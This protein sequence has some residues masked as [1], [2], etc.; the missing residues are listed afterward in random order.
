MCT[1][2][3]LGSDV[4]LPTS[5]WSL[6]DPRFHVE[7]IDAEM[8]VMTRHFFKPNVYYLASHE[9]CGCGFEWDS[10]E[11]L[12]DVQEWETEWDTLSEELR[13]EIDWSRS[14]ER[15]EYENR[16]NV[17]E[18]LASLLKSVLE[19]TNDLELRVFMRG[20]WDKIPT[21]VR[22]VTPDELAQGRPDV[23]PVEGVLYRVTKEKA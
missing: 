13:N 9:G 11:Q 10:R 20:E 5:K 16:K 3:L 18:D 15:R 1:H 14:D 23:F 6:E 21:S 7:N 19:R 8:R 2:V 17:A 22:S 4:E 12:K